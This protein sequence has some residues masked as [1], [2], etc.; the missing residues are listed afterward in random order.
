MS[1][2]ADCMYAIKHKNGTYF[3]S[4]TAIGPMFGGRLRGKNMS[5]AERFHSKHTAQAMIDRDWKMTGSKVVEV[6]A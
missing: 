4:Y 3:V 2:K 1:D 6:K 5:R